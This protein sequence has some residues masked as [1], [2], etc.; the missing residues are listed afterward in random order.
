MNTQVYELY[1]IW[2]AVEFLSILI[3]AS[4]H[5]VKKLCILFNFQYM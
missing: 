2:R 3:R 1:L 5:F 4:L